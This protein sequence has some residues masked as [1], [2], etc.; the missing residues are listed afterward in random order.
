MMT[1]TLTAKRSST[2]LKTIQA[3]RSPA[4]ATSISTSVGMSGTRSATTA[5]LS[6]STLPTR[7]HLLLHHPLQHLLVAAI[8]MKILRILR[9]QP[10]RTMMRALRVT[11]MLTSPTLAADVLMLKAE[12]VVAEGPADTQLNLC[13]RNLLPV[14][15][16]S[17]TLATCCQP[18]TRDLMRPLLTPAPTAPSPLTPPLLTADRP[19][20]EPTSQCTIVTL[21]PPVL[22][23][24]TDV[25][26][27]VASAVSAR[28]ASVKEVSVGDASSSLTLMDKPLVDR[29]RDNSVREELL[30][31]SILIKMT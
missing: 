11:P 24:V 9:T 17:L 13:M 10:P 30:M 1:S 3:V 2:T 20:Q 15:A 26:R 28:V 8:Q 5:M 16:V 4:R 29:S 6:T 7:G 25:D 23:V 18:V 31:T 19:I 22:V 14:I 12:A 21:L 27:R